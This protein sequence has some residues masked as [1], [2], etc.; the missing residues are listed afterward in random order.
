MRW[1]GRLMTSAA[2]IVLAA[3][4]ASAAS[5]KTAS[6]A[7]AAWASAVK[8]GTLEAYAAFAM[9]FP[10]SEHAQA[11]YTRLSTA[12]VR[13]EARVDDGQ[14]EETKSLGIMSWMLVV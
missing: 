13:R 1:V 12:A 7:D 3:G 5:E 14:G 8:R 10:E 6:P 11:A 2:A 9:T 4:G